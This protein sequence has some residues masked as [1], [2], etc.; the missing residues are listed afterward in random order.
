VQQVEDLCPGTLCYS[1]GGLGREVHTLVAQ[2]G[3]LCSIAKTEVCRPDS[4]RVWVLDGD[5]FA[6][7]CWQLHGFQPTERDPSVRGVYWDRPV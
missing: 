5:S 7:R 3:G 6:E 2:E 4:L 1:D